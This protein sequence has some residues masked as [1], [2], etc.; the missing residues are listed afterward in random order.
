MAYKKPS[1]ITFYTTYPHDIW[2]G[3][4]NEYNEPVS[5]PFMDTLEFVIYGQA[6]A[7]AFV[8]S[9]DDFVRYDEWLNY[10]LQ[11]DDLDW[12]TELPGEYVYSLELKDGGGNEWSTSGNI[13]LI[14]GLGSGLTVT[15]LDLK[16]YATFCVF[17]P[18]NGPTFPHSWDWSAVQNTMLMETQF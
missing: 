11:A 15:L 4:Y 14:E 12:A 1:A 3:V 13:R 7:P 16:I 2:I 18:G 17:V 5:N 9:V 10:K 6:G 8:L